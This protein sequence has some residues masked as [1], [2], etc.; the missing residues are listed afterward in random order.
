M[1]DPVRRLRR[2]AL[3]DYAV[4]NLDGFTVADVMTD[5]GLTHAQTNITIR[6]LRLW[7]CEVGDTINLTADPQGQNDRWLY[8]L[9]GTL[10]E[11][12]PWATNRV[13]DTESRIR[14][15]K[16]IWCTIVAATDGRSTEGRKA[17]VMQRAFTRLIED[18]DTIETGMG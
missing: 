17:R 2:E 15:Q 11:A 16:A 14:T 6:D 7:L 8:R 18:L 1:T 13:R 10:D 3:L 5:L 12:R 4:A 9:V